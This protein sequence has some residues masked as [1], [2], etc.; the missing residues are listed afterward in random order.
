MDLSP[1]LIVE[2]PPHKLQLLLLQHLATFKTLFYR[3]DAYLTFMHVVKDQMRFFELF[4]FLKKRYICQANQ[5]MR[6]YSLQR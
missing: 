2:E 1:L 6:N 4:F 5:L 3:D